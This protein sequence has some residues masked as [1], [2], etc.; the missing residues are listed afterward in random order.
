MLKGLENTKSRCYTEVTRS[1]EKR[2]QHQF[3]KKI[4]TSAIKNSI[5]FVVLLF[6]YEF[7]LISSIEMQVHWVRFTMLGH[8]T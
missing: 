7:I 3:Y 8:S 5:Y 1:L 4:N 6:L 2:V